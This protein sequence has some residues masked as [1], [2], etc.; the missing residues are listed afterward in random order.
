MGVKGLRGQGRRPGWV[1]VLCSWMRHFIPTKLLS[2]QEYKWVVVSC[3]GSP[4]KC[5][6]VTLQWTGIPSR[7]SGDVPSQSM[8]WKLG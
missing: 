5:C 4:M 1:I 6:G 2:T 8:L 7:G 3:K